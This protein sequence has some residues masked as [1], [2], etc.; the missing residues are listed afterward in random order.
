VQKAAVLGTGLI[1]TSV[2]A[3][4]RSAG[5]EVAGW[6]PDPTAAIAARE[7]NGF[8]RIHPARADALDGRELIVL[9][10]PPSAV[11]DDLAGMTTDALVTDVAGVKLPVVRAAAHLPHFVGGHPMAG[12]EHAGPAAASPALFRGASWIITTDGAH[13]YDLARVTAVVEEL[14]AVPVRMTAAEHDAAVAAV[15]HL[16]QVIASLLVQ[17]ADRDPHA[18]DLAAGS[19]RDLTRVAL[20]EPGWWAELLVANRDQLR[21]I[22][23]SMTEALTGLDDLLA[24]GAVEELS[25][26]MG[27]AR[28]VRRA[29]APP[30][31]AV[32]VVMEDRPGELGAVGRALAVSGVDVRDLQLR[33]APHGGGGLLTLSVRPGEAETLR[34]ALIA[35]GFALEQ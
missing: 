8:D 23:R 16:P 21:P 19:F 14:G 20:S 1:G 2:G 9:A 29:M 12:R 22:L 4:L 24:V 32:D 27:K 7:M 15:S 3:A 6:D 35:E 18:L 34:A 28:S 26:G 25:A 13:E 30:V 10:G 33:H 11:V 31:V 17:V 5:W